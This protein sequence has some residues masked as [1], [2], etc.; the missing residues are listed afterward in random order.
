MSLTIYYHPLS[1]PSRS[2]LTFLHLTDIKYEGR[3]IDLLKGEHK[4]EEFAKINPLKVIPAI[5][6]GSLNL[7]ESEAIV[8]YLMNTRKVGAM[9]YPN[10]PQ[11]RA[12]VD[13]YFPF[14]HSTFRPS[15]AKFFV[16]AF[17]FLFPDKKIDLEQAQIDLQNALK[18]FETVFIT[19]GKYIAGDIL[20]IADIFA[21]NELTQVYYTTD[22]D[23]SKYPGIKDYIERCVQNPVLKNVNKPIR[24][25][26]EQMKAKGQQA[27]QGD[28]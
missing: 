21:V 23:F 10:D 14:H 17:P 1:Q 25:F 6:D 20:T 15:L 19:S 26:G 9:Y 13:R 2:I 27:K 5:T 28:Q 24:D 8:K 7:A 11:T 18:T 3:V 16:A 12:L 22:V 4:T